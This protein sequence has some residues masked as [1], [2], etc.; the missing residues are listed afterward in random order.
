VRTA[1]SPK[2]AGSAGGQK[3]GGL[4]NGGMPV[5]VAEWLG[6]VQRTQNGIILL[7]LNQPKNLSTQTAGITLDT[8][9]L[10][11]LLRYRVQ[12]HLPDLE[13]E[14]V[15]VGGVEDGS[16]I[17]GLPL[18]R[19]SPEFPVTIEMPD[20]RQMMEREIRMKR[21]EEERVQREAMAR[22]KREEIERVRREKER[23]KQEQAEREKR[24]LLDLYNK[25]ALEKKQ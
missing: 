12:D 8:Q 6:S 1:K 20:T 22:V 24:E 23:V 2:R 14:A 7:N 13:V 11:L 19:A 3:A 17:V 18:L 5:T 4:G 9:E 25:H 21:E 15:D 16:S 10:K